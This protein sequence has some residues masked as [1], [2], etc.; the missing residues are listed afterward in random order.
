MNTTLAPIAVSKKFIIEN[1]FE[2]YLYS[3]SEYTG[4]SIQPSGKFEFDLS[5]LN[6]YWEKEDHYPHLVLCEE[7]LAGF[8]LLRRYPYESE[9]HDIGQFFILNKFQG[10]GVGRNAFIQSVSKFPG[11]WLTRI[12]VDNTGAMGFWTK[13]IGET[14]NGKYNMGEELYEGRVRMNFIWYEVFTQ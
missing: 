8:S 4:F 12:R 7:E 1:L 5:F 13:V 6:D 14:T 10:R 9:Y 11:K 2:L 3:M